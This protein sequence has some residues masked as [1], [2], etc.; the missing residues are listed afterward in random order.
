MV[1]G[2][3]YKLLLTVCEHWNAKSIFWNM[4]KNRHWV[5]RDLPFQNYFLISIS[6]G[7]IAYIY[8]EEED[9]RTTKKTE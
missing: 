3:I 8:S 5:K 2:W 1:D 9:W 7:V 6:F 4:L